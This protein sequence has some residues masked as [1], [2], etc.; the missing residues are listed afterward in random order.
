MTID[1]A[2]SLSARLRRALFGIPTKEIRCDTRGF[3]VGT[4]A[5]RDRIEQV[6]A[7]FAAGYHAAL[8]ETRP[9]PL[10]AAL[11]GIEPERRGFAYEGAAM[12]LALLDL[13]TP[14]SGRRFAAFLAGPGDAHAYML[15]VGAGWALARLPR[16]VEVH[17]QRFDPLMRWLVLD[18]Y[19]FHQGYFHWRHYVAAQALPRNLSDYGRRAF[20]QGLG[21]SL[22]FVYGA[23]PPVIAARIAGFAPQRAADLWSGVG[24]A[25]AYAGGVDAPAL[26]ELL[27]LAETHRPLLAQGAAFAAKARQRAGNPAPH[28]ELAC[29][30]LCGLDA[31]TAAALTDRMLADLPADGALPAYEHWRRR[32]QERL[33]GASDAAAPSAVR[34]AHPRPI[35]MAAVG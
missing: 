14:L 2:P 28:T 30:T 6:G 13:L 20:D 35:A 1:T 26:A 32:I 8:L 34:E 24:L 27:G 29:R 3:S 10:A 33:R 9:A 16:R 23:E 22:W 18:G 21:R 19:G 7:T 11:D 12:A 25:A 15:H 4:P 5:T 17:L 31:D